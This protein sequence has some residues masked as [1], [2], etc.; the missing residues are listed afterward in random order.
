[1]M[2]SRSPVRW[3]L[4]AT[5][6]VLMSTCGFSGYDSLADASVCDA[7]ATTFTVDID[8]RFF[9]LPAG[10]RVVLE[11]EEGGGHLLV[12]ITALE[13]TETVAGVETRVVE[14]YEAKSGR[15]IEIS[16]NFFAQAQ[17]GTVC[18]FGEDVDIYDGAG[19]ITSHLGAWRAG[20]G[21]NRPGIFM[22]SSLQVGQAF[23]QEIAPG[24]AEDQAKVIALGEA[25]DVPAGTF[26][27]TVTM[28][29]GSP[30]DGSTGEKV[31]ARD[32][33]LIVDGPARLTKYS[34][35]DA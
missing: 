24:I 30:L 14:E 5:S 8:N 32:I 26:D 11:G 28:R 31:Y 6:T 16:R 34:S 4:M 10:H 9:P 33:G 17:D 12:R 3:I 18:Y 22:P 23:Q 27:D 1:M 7:R 35:P 13:E 29:D 21:D 2:T 19:N 15:V 20:Q 25:T